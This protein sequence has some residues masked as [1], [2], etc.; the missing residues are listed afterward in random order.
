MPGGRGGRRR[1]PSRRRRTVGRSARSR[2]RSRSGLLGR[3]GPG[4]LSCIGP[5]TGQQYGFF[6]FFFFCST[7]LRFTYYHDDLYLLSGERCPFD[8]PSD[9][10]NR[11]RAADCTRLLTYVGGVEVECHILKI[12]IL[13][14]IW[15]TAHSR[16]H[17]QVSRPCATGPIMSENVLDELEPILTRIRHALIGVGLPLRIVEA[18]GVQL[19]SRSRSIPWSTWQPR[20]Q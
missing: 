2:G 3:R 11:L 9:H 14:T 8:L 10:A 5:G 19:R 12:T 16:Q 17:R 4:R 6:F 20:T 15:P 7:S 18:S 1:A 13:G